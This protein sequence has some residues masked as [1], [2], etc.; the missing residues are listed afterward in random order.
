MSLHN[1]SSS[2]S[3]Y[4]SI[5]VYFEFLIEKF[6]TLHFDEFSKLCHDHDCS[7]N[8]DIIRINQSE[9]VV[10]GRVFNRNIEESVSGFG[11]S[12]IEL[13][14][15]N[16]VLIFI[17]NGTSE[18]RTPDVYLSYAFYYLGSSYAINQ[19]NKNEEITGY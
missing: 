3:D 11:S 19:V 18:L 9:K 14:T 1:T 15:K 2:K 6:F 4:H 12:R 16:E 7:Q 13:N 8:F 17:A 10:V 5:F